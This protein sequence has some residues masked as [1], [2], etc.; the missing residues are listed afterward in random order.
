MIFTNHNHRRVKGRKTYLTGK[1][2]NFTLQHHQVAI[3][4]YI[5]GL[6]RYLGIWWGY[7][8][9]VQTITIIIGIGWGYHGMTDFWCKN[10][11]NLSLGIHQLTKPTENTTLNEVSMF[12]LAG[13]K[14]DHMFT[15]F[16]WCTCEP[17]WCYGWGGG[18]GRMNLHVDSKQKRM[19]LWKRC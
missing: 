19:R 12:L 18:W 2:V 8:R 5:M 14:P 15:V 13:W 16:C 9:G 4:P 7:N 1:H 11:A 3:S 10:W 17:F 6:A